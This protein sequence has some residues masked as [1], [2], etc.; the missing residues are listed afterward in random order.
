MAIYRPEREAPRPWSRLGL[1]ALALAALALRW[2]RG[3]AEAFAAAAPRLRGEGLRA[4][5]PRSGLLQPLRAAAE[6]A[7]EEAADDDA[8]EEPDEEE[9]DE[10]EEVD[11]APDM[12]SLEQPPEE[13]FEKRK[14]YVRNVKNTVFDMFKKP[15]NFFPPK[16]QPGD[17]V[18][19]YY[20][21]P[22]ITGDRS[23]YPDFKSFDPVKD[24]Q[25]AYFDGIIL[26]FQ[27]E[28]HLRKMRIRSMVGQG[29]YSMGMELVLPIH[30]PLVSRIDVLRRGYIGQ[31]KNAMWMRAMVGKNN[32]IPLDVERTQ[33]DTS[34]DDLRSEGRADEIPE[35]NYPQTEDEAFPLPRS[36]QFKDDWK[37]S[38]YD[39]EKVD[40]RT[41]YERRILGTF[42]KRLNPSGQYGRWNN[43]S[44]P[45]RLAWR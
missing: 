32:I 29:A 44:P 11:E 39:P 12:M 14:V 16:L 28:D 36:A 13:W 18:R 25:E 17:T 27:S 43:P 22:K 45:S 21:Q 6:G 9:E 35:S 41:E 10:V 2:A 34:F 1:A 7:A 20:Q 26:E 19:V 37:E 8:A 30:S 38:E 31:N 40:Q 24:M 3:P 5:A 42:R 33:M 15:K 4:T 23:H